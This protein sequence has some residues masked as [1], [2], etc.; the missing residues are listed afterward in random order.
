M[1]KTEGLGHRRTCCMQESHESRK[2]WERCGSWT[3][4]LSYVVCCTALL[5][6]TSCVSLPVPGQDP[7][8]SRESLSWKVVLEKRDPN[9]LLAGDRTQCEVSADRYAS[10]SEGDRVF[11]HWR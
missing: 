1:K 5:L 10:V 4:G 9:I 6:A 2:R 11:C 7:A 8:R 3:V